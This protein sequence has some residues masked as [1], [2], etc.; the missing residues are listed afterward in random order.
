MHCMNI[1]AVANCGFLSNPV[2]G[3]VSFEPDGFTTF[4]SRAVYTCN[5]GFTLDGDDTRVCQADETWS[6]SAPKCRRK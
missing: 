6:G 4:N 2:D 5:S 1:Y 3:Q